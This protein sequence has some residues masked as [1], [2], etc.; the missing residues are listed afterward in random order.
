MCSIEVDPTG[1]YLY[2]T[3]SQGFLAYLQKTAAPAGHSTWPPEK[4]LVLDVNIL[5]IRLRKGL[6]AISRKLEWRTSGKWFFLSTLIGIVTG[7]GAIAFQLSCQFISH[8]AMGMGAGFYPGEPAGEYSPFPHGT[9]VISP[10]RFLIVISIGGLISGL[11]VYFFAPEAAGHG[12]DAAIDAFHNK[13]GV[14]KWR[15]PIIKTITSAI[16]I[17]TGG[18]GGREG[19]IAQI[20][21]GFGSFLGH[22]LKLPPR[23]CR[24]MLAAGMAAGVGSIFRAPLAG[25]LFAAEIMYRDADLESDV[26]VP[27]AMSSIIGYSVYSLL[28]PEE[29]RFTPLFGQKLDFAISSPF[30]LIPYF[31]LAI[32]MAFFGYLYIKIFYGVHDYFHKK[33][34]W[35]HRGLRPCLGAFITGLIGIGLYY[36]WD[37]DP[38][39]LSVFSTGYATLQASFHPE[40]T[41]GVSLLL[42]VAFFKILT[43]AFTIGSGGSGGVFGPSMVIGGCAGAATG[44]ILQQVMPEGWVAHPETFSIVGMAG[45]F[46]GC[47]HAPIST[48]IMVSEM[49]GDYK[50]LVPT[51]WV[52]TLCFLVM[53]P[54]TLYRNQVKSPLESPAHKGDFIIDILEGIKVENVYQKDRKLTLIH[55]SMTLEEIVH[56]IALSHQHYYPV[57]DDQGRMVGIFS[58]DDVRSYLYDETIWKLAVAR[59]VMVGAGH[60]VSVTPEDNLNSV[61][62]RFTSRNLDELPVL[63]MKEP[64][65]LLGM[66]R[67]KETIAYYNRRLVELKQQADDES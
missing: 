56:Q 47:A 62:K 25:A 41:P 50:L 13:R 22:V 44:L 55:E 61:L 21:S 37:K 20:G 34:S 46:A 39:L 16:T 10:W 52:S 15:T 58:S 40:T 67:R 1:R 65:K 51:M 64:G 6:R 12:T 33:M 17:G 57:V 38:L 26:I 27:A 5:L 49:I 43:T 59:D 28:L 30:E 11:I 32:A 29:L 66:L 53:R 18:S 23:D 14:V 60:V 63:S 7:I 36:W 45:F 35:L 31:L 2:V 9:A 3:N 24:I 42:T 19:P 8:Y 48:I 4:R 54:W